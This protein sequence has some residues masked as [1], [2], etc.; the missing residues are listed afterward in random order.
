MDRAE[1]ERLIGALNAPSG[2]FL[3]MVEDRDEYREQLAAL[4]PGR[5]FIK[6]RDEIALT[7]VYLPDVK[8]AAVARVIFADDE[9]ESPGKPLTRA[10][11][12]NA[13]KHYGGWPWEPESE[14]R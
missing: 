5:H 4:L 6:P 1:L 14:A 10:E 2:A 12:H 8:S 7:S 13:W 11:E 3:F 9:F